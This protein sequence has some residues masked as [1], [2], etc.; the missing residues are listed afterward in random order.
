MSEMWPKVA[1]NRERYLAALVAQA[2]DDLDERRLTVE[3]ALA[4]IASLAYAAG[5]EH[6]CT[7]PESADR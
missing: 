4:S 7:E 2:L 6:G 3:Q 1:V 5:R